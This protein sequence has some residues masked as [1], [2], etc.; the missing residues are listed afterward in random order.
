MRRGQV[1]GESVWEPGSLAPD[2]ASGG[3]EVARDPWASL[4]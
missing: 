1:A 4:Q 3:R 2:A